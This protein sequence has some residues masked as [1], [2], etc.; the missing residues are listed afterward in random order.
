PQAP[1]VAG[2]AFGLTIV[3]KDQYGNVDNNFPKAITLT[4]G[5]PLSGTLTATLDNHLLSAGV[6]TVTN[7][8]LTNAAVVATIQATSPGVVAA[9]TNPITVIPASASKLVVTAPPPASI[10]A[11]VAFGLTIAAQ[12][13]SGN[14][15]STYGSGGQTATIMLATG[16]AGVTFAPV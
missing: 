4:S 3:A 16:P 6:A 14:I 8:I 15:D 1:V 5:A 11:G 10:T 9:I 7:V 2:A 12:D 13:P